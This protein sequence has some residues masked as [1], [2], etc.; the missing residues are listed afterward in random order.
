MLRAE[1]FGNDIER[2][3]SFSVFPQ[4]EDESKLSSVAEKRKLFTDLQENMSS[5]GILSFLC[6]F[7]SL[8]YKFRVDC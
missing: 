7:C 4:D 6:H 5:T 1:L 8:L 2:G 3:V